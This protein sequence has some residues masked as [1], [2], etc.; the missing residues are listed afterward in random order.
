M[1]ALTGEYPDNVGDP[2]A[3]MAYLDVP[4]ESLARGCF[5]GE[6]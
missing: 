5:R 1:E 3:G 2:N 6:L 4:A